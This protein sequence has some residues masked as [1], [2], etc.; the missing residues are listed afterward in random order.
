MP[1]GNGSLPEGQTTSQDLLKL[2]KGGPRSGEGRFNG[3]FPESK[4]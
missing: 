4:D 2:L 1:E 3:A